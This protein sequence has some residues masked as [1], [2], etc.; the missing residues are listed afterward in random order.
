MASYKNVNTNY[1]LNVGPNV[2]NG[3]G[4]YGTFTINADL[5]VTGNTT[6]V[7]PASNASPF[8]TVAANNTGGITDMGLLAQI[9]GNSFAGLRFDVGSGQWQ[10]SNS[11]NLSLIHI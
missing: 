1:T 2:A 8:F 10:I 6:Y 9:N 3:V 11:V 7:Q 4:S 5:V